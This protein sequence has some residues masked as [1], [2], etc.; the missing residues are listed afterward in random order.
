MRY[1][2][3]KKAYLFLQISSSFPCFSFCC[4]QVSVLQAPAHSCMTNDAV[5]NNSIGLSHQAWEV[6]TC[7][8]G[9]KR[10]LATIGA[11]KLWQTDRPTE[12][13]TDMRVHRE[14]RL[15][16]IA[17]FFPPNK[18]F[19]RLSNMTPTKRLSLDAKKLKVY[20][21]R[22]LR[23]KSWRFALTPRSR[24]SYQAK[25]LT[26]TM[27]LFEMSCWRKSQTITPKNGSRTPNSLVGCRVC[28]EVERLRHDG[29][30]PVRVLRLRPESGH[31]VY[32]FFVRFSSRAKMYWTNIKILDSKFFI[33]I[34]VPMQHGLKDIQMLTM[35]K[36]WWNFSP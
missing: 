21:K 12:K 18:S 8:L 25:G 32:S 22:R 3:Q 33:E 14:V 6:S 36:V 31:H 5:S 1:V 10:L 26:L 4:L 17:S 11:W 19:S 30:R 13:Q 7:K 23:Q 27:T 15:P 20:I 35:L 34:F 24:A 9:I 28:K 16:T 29:K 2:K